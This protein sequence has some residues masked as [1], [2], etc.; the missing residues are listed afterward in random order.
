M[1]SSAV[2]LVLLVVQASATDVCYDQGAFAG[3]IIASFVGGFILAVIV[4]V[5]VMCNL[6]KGFFDGS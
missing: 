6:C 3:I 5:L 2:L 1:K 4:G